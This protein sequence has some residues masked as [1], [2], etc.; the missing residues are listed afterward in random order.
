MR[1]SP[2]PATYRT[3]ADIGRFF[4]A[5]L[6]RVRALPGARFAGASTGL[7]LANISGDW[8]FDI[9]GLPFA[10]GKRHSGQLDWYAVTPGYFE[11]LRIPL[12]KG[13]FPQAGDD[14]QSTA[15]AIFINEAAMRQFFPNGDAVGHRIRLSGSDQPWR[16][17]AGVVGDVR[18]RGLD[19][20]VSA[21]MFI[22]LAQFKHFSPTG[23]A[24]GLTVVIRSEL[25][26]MQMLPA[27]RNALRALDPEVPPAQ[28]QDMPSVVA[29]SVADRRLNMVLMGS[30]GLL[31]LTL[32]AIGIYGV[33][34]Y[35]VTQR[36]REM[37]VRLALGASP[38]SVRELVV[39]D[40][41]RLVAIGL[42][43]GAAGALAL[44]R[45]LEHLLFGVDGRDLATLIGSALLLA[46]VGFIAC[47]LPARRATRV[48][49]MLALR[50]E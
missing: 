31:A 45:L 23:Q 18:H 37:G 50:T 10:P 14:M 33:M 27:V 8:S 49:P 1:L 3:Q 4:D 13:R 42:A 26:P 46:I 17:I 24:R 39:R 11:S 22:P 48:D 15:P 38:D 40:G 43:L 41:M 47:Y 2:P 20:P 30:F 28:I 21:E 5:F 35:Q 9:E 36:T 32:A 44:S 7:P 19:T 25:D 29:A 34:G 12:V 16:T 6:G